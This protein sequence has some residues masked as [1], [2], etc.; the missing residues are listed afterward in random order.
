MAKNCTLILPNTIGF[1]YKRY[2]M[3]N[4][5]TFCLISQNVTKFNKKY[6]NMNK[7]NDEK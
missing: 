4:L 5:L 1:P 6:N 2:G 7:I 3:N